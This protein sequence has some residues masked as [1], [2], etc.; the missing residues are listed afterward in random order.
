MFQRILIPLDGST[1]AERAIPVAARIARASGAAIILL[2]V[3]ATP[4][5]EKGHRPG[6]FPL[7]RAVTEADI[8]AAAAYLTALTTSNDFNLEGFGV[9]TRVVPGHAAPAILDVAGEEQADLIVMC[10]H[11]ETGLKRWFVDSIAQDVAQHSPVPVLFLGEDSPL[12][13]SSYPDHLHP[14]R[15]LMGLVA[16]DGSAFAEA[17]LEPTAALVDSLAAPARGT[18]LLTRVV[19]LPEPRIDHIHHEYHV[20]GIMEQEIEEAKMYLGSLAQRLRSGPLARLNLTIVWSLSISRDVV[21]S[22]IEYAES[23]KDA[24]GM[25][26]YGSSDVIALATHGRA[27]LQR[28]ALGSVS[29][30]LLEATNRPL[31]V[32]HPLTTESEKQLTAEAGQSEALNVAMQ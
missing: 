24:D 29:W 12:P 13:L 7:T 3:A 31:L 28:L 5:D 1:R 15:P 27:G 20:P 9:K 30:H 4:L 22:L 14:L 2:R 23:G 26:A 18:L 21:G 8:D 10:G 17:A 32:V 16:L 25:F 6:F 19:P 11:S